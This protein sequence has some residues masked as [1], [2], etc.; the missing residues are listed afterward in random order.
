MEA[1][2]ADE[3][4]ALIGSER[5]R[6]VTVW[7][8]SSVVGHLCRNRRVPDKGSYTVSELFG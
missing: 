3:C 6:C 5:R 7:A 1:S 8:R 4:A 2:S